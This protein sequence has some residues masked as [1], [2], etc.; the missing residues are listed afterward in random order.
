MPPATQAGL[1]ECGQKPG[2]LS[3]RR[4]VRRGGVGAVD[5]GVP[6][7]LQQVILSIK[8][9]EITA[10]EPDSTT[11]IQVVTLSAIQSPQ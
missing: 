4:G 8:R 6:F 9:L 10:L 11:Y 3:G 7:N 2:G 1:G 5:S